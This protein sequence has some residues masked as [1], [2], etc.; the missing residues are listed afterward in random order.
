MLPNL[1]KQN[2]HKEADSS[3][4]LR[5]WLKAHPQ[6]TCSLEVKDTRGKNSLPFS[7]V[8]QAQ[9]DYAEAIM[10]DRGVLLRT[11]AVVEGMPDYIYLRNEPAY[12]VI[13]YPQVIHIISASNFVFEKE[14]SKR[15][16]LTQERAAAIATT[17]IN[18][19][20]KSPRGVGRLKRG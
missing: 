12:I 16:S 4:I 10:S 9:L 18:L 3:L 1:P 6:E 15:K 14:R 8:K 20:A 13:R 19:N 5:H 17:S 7:E 2:R 11:Q